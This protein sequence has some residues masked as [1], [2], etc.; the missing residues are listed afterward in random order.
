[1]KHDPEPKPD[2]ESQYD[3]TVGPDS[4]YNDDYVQLSE[5]RGSGC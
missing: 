2:D 1:M 3:N 5:G 4:P